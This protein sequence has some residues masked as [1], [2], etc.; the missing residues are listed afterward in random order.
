[1]CRVR[2]AIHAIGSDASATPAP[3]SGSA[4]NGL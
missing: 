3:T 2:S 1:M 4:Q